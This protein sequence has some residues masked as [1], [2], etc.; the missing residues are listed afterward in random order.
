MGTDEPVDLLMISWNR[1][2]YLEKTLAR[3]LNDPS[4]FRLHWWDNGSTD[5]AADLMAETHDPRI[6]HKHHCPTN[7]M[8]GVPTQW[9]LEQAKS[10]VIGKIDD[11]TLIPPRWSEPIAAAVRAHDELGMVG[12]WTFWMDDYERNRAAADGRVVQFGEHGVMQ[13]A[14]IGG[15]A[16]LIRKELAKRYHN[17]A[18]SGREFAINR[19]KMTVDGYIS[20]WYY[21]LI[22]A[23]HMDDPRSEHCLMTDAAGIDGQAALTARARGF[24]APSQYLNWIKRDAD[25]ALTR[26]VRQQV[27]RWRWQNSALKLFA[28]RTRVKVLRGFI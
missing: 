13:A 16:V 25:Q 15:T 3:L 11:D 1:R 10:D 9:F 19:I 7:A 22:W 21:P 28:D 4:D 8:Q 14:W 27:R 23:E 18:S 20:G 2:A 5:G 26:G 17:R 24:T 6:V 12:C